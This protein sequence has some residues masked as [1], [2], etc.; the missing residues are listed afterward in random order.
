MTLISNMIGRKIVMAVTGLAMSLYVSIHLLGN[1]SVFSG[2]DGINAYAKMLHS[3]GPLLWVIRLIMA[4]A[5]GLH[6]VFG[7][8]LFFENRAAKPQRYA[9]R[10]DLS[11]TF[12]GKNMIW[13]GLLIALYLGYHLLH[14][15]VQVVSPEF[16]AS[17]NLDALGR[18]D[19]FSMVMYNFRNAVVSI[20]YVTAMAAVGLHL[21]HGLQSIVQTLGLNNERTLP[22]TIKISAA[23]ALAL[24]LGYAAI[25]AGIISRLAGR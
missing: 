6:M 7:I 4:A 10:K 13:T 3:L 8:Q 12:A 24:F 2:P 5:L 21:T 11:A 20:I 17:R 14:F 9:V 18:P 1:M 16:S 15:T 19:V 22:V 23:A 25:P